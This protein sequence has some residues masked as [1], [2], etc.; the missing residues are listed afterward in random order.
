MALFSASFFTV[1]L[2]AATKL[3]E[4]IYQTEANTISV[5]YPAAEISVCT[6]VT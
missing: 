5:K 1:V 3:T 4:A 6:N 2:K